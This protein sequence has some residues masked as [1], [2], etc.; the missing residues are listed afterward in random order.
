MATTTN[1]QRLLTQV[2]AQAR[3]G[4]DASEERPVLEQVVL[5]LCRDGATTPEAE[6]ALANL[7]A[8][9][10]DWNE[11]RVSSYREVEEALEPLPDAEAKAHRILLF[12][13]E[14]FEI[15]VSFDLEKLRKEGLKQAVKKLSR[16]KAADDF[17]CAWVSQR[18]LGGHAL[19]LDAPSLRCGQR[20]GLI[21]EGRDDLEAVRTSLE[22]HVPKA[23]GLQFIEGLSL[24]ACTFCDEQPRCGE[25]PLS[26]ECPAAGTFAV[27]TPAPARRKPK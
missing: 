4:T 12:L 17:V 22:H 2:L 3:K 5:G 8:R 16:F 15:H 23:K 20:L 21:D 6:A 26:R 13:Q 18:S 11:I 19:P 10:F 14:V 7:K 27:E 1:K 25:C 24:V 9:F